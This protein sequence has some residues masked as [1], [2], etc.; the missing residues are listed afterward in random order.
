MII[1]T[2]ASEILAHTTLEVHIP[3]ETGSLVQ[4]HQAFFKKS[5]PDTLLSISPKHLD[6]IF[7]SSPARKK[8]GSK[9]WFPLHS[10]NTLS[11]IAIGIYHQV[12][13]P[14]DLQEHI[15]QAAAYLKDTWS[16]EGDIIII[17]H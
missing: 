9:G 17:A 3:K 5:D 6:E 8:S 14:N 7:G 4:T 12:I 10:E 2:L 11:T 1:G 16:Y 13:R 15:N